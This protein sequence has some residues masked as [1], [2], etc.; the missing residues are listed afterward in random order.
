MC[1][2]QKKQKR[3]KFHFVIEGTVFRIFM[4]FSLSAIT[5]AALY[6]VIDLLYYEMLYWIRMSV[7]P[8][9]LLNFEVIAQTGALNAQDDFAINLN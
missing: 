5:I 2:K 8:S 9:V 6:T 1:L 7:K 4:L 3:T